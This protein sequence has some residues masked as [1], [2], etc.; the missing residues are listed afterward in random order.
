MPLPPR[1]RG[2]EPGA[3]AQI[4]SSRRRARWG[5]RRTAWLAAEHLIRYFNYW[6]LKHRPDQVVGNTPNALQMT[7]F[8]L[9]VGSLE[10]TVRRCPS[11]PMGQ[12]RGSKAVEVLLSQFCAR[13]SADEKYEPHD[14]RQDITVS[15]SSINVDELRLPEQAGHL[16]TRVL[17]PPD[18]GEAFADGP[19]R[20]A[21]PEQ[22]VGVPPRPCYM[23]PP[24]LERELRSRLLAS[25]M[26]VLIPEG[27][28]AKRED[29]RLLLN[30]C[31]G[32]AHPKGMRAIFDCRPANHG[33]RRMRWMSLPCG[34]MLVNCR[35]RAHEALRGSGDDLSNWFYQLSECSDLVSR[36]AFGRSVSSEESAALGYPAVPHRMALRVL[37]MGSQNGPDIAQAVHEFVLRA[38]DCMRPEHVLRYRAPVP[39]TNVLEGVYLDDHLVIH[40]CPLSDL[41]TSTGPDRELILSS[42]EA[43]RSFGVDRSLQKAFGYSL[44]RMPARADAV[45]KAWGLKLTAAEGRFR[46]RLPSGWSC[47][48]WWCLPWRRRAPTRGWYIG[49]LGCWCFR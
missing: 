29:G 16:D 40:I 21:P 15:A 33:E 23:V 45:F 27:A 43:Y 28:V 31:F 20:L 22:I 39:P 2:F 5:V 42:H 24:H 4:A 10:G 18:L 19:R 46:P 32:V 48:V 44:P 11:V 9:F 8:E 3:G 34:P 37:G 38:H 47:W 12:G 35:L 30:G 7:A 13:W 17:L 49:C 25:R 41:D 36:R 1:P 6:E 14:H 26:A